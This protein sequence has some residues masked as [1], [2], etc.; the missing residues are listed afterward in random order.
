M[1]PTSDE[2]L[3]LP[4]SWYHTIELAPGITTP[5]W[6]DIRHVVAATGLPE[7]LHGA[8]ALD[9]GMYDG[10]WAFELERRGAT[11]IGLDID[12][13]P[14]PDTPA[15]HRARM[16]AEASTTPGAGFEVLRRYFG[17]EVQRVSCNVYDLTPEA[18]GGPVDLAVVGALLLHLRDPVRA[19]ERVRSALSPGGSLVLVEPTEPALDRGRNARPEARFM[20]FESP[21]TWWIP[22]AA[23]LE[24]WLRTAQ[25]GEV[26]VRRTVKAPDVNGFTHHLTVVHAR[27]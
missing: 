25:F 14:P 10:F 22:N 20:A 9:V 27:P 18:V 13:I 8:R 1:R 11:V 26:S 2:V 21:W 16:E 23:C 19:L 17:S 24:H 6:I 7:T 15:L 3:A 4:H 12:E 5:G